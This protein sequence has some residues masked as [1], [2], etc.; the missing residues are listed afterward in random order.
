M[1]GQRTTL[2]TGGAGYVGSVLVPELLASGRTVRVL[3]SLL[4]GVLPEPI[5]SGDGVELVQ[6]DVR[7]DDLRRAALEGVDEVVH[8]AAIV[9]DP[10]CSREPDEARSVNLEATR[11][12]VREAHDGGVR[13]FV[14]A[15]TCSNY[16]KLETDELATE[17]WELHPVSLYAETKVAAELDILAQS[18]N[19]FSAT[20]L[21]LATV[22]GASPRMRFDLTVNEFTRDVVLGRELVVYGEQFWRPY[23]HVRD[24]ARGILLVLDSPAELVGSRVFNL[25]DSAEN[26]RKLDLVEILRSRVPDANVSFVHRTEDPRDYR[27]SF[28]KIGAALGYTVSMRV[29]DGIDEVAALV[30]S[31]AVED[32]FADV[33][34]N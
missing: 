8:L 23:V 18:G 33:Y 22:Y 11:L 20:C 14:F 25:G 4:H 21:R 32:P 16:G 29:P 17:D 15:S 2:V 27:V 34:R 7:D 24:A 31:G 12:L 26:Y 3:D 6:G 1:S 13:R 5:A 9:G 10:A 30:S 28:E 19:G